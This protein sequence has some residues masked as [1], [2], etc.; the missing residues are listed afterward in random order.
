[1]GQSKI[2]NTTSRIKMQI[3]NTSLVLL[4]CLSLTLTF[5]EAQQIP[6]NNYEFNWS[7]SKK[8]D[9]DSFFADS[10]KWYDA[11]KEARNEDSEGEESLFDMDFPMEPLVSNFSDSHFSLYINGKEYQPEEMIEFAKK[12][13]EDNFDSTS[14]SKFTDETQ[15]LDPNEIAD[16]VEPLSSFLLFVPLLSML[17]LLL[18]LPIILLSVFIPLLVVLP[19][20]MFLPFVPLLMFLPFLADFASIANVATVANTF[21]KVATVAN[22]VANVT[23][24]ANITT[25]APTVVSTI[26]TT[27]ANEIVNLPKSI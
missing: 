18:V 22:T 9:I 26:A 8:I 11:T 5:K 17:P 2:E 10:K 6:V 7:H 24:V 19:F 25:I 16:I 23:N 4:F 20:T 1:M 27:I 21:A 15:A 3:R 13:F 12:I 14:L